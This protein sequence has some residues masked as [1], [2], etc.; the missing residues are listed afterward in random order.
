MPCVRSTRSQSGPP[1]TTD[2]EFKAFVLRLMPLYFAHPENGGPE[3]F[4]KAW[5]NM[6]SLWAYGAYYAAD[7]GDE[8]KWDQVA[9]LGN[10]S[11]KTLVLT[12]RQDRTAGVEVSEAIAGGV[13][14][15]KLVV[16]EECGHM[17]WVE[18]EEEFWGVLE[19]FLAEE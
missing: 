12:G 13:K 8:G 15:S 5:T 1:I 10:V 14:G 19:G 17:P 16:L 7:A 18:K 2:A 9:E 4:A 11:G 6:P 3:A